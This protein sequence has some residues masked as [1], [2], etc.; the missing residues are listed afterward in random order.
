MVKTTP[1]REPSH[2][3]RAR[4]TLEGGDDRTGVGLRLSRLRPL[5][6][7]VRVF[8]RFGTLFVP[9]SAPGPILFRDGAALRLHDAE[10]VEEASNIA[11]CELLA[12]TDFLS[13][14]RDPGIRTRIDGERFLLQMG[15]LEALH[16]G[17]A[18]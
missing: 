18:G 15:I 14:V 3:C 6:S 16:G 10:P 13:M 8:G 11:G 9:L 17:R 12:H 5:P 4:L 2:E 1:D 7:G